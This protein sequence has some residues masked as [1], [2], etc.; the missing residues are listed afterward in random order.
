MG[1]RDIATNRYTE[2]CIERSSGS[3][4]CGNRSRGRH[5]HA[6]GVGIGNMASS[7][8]RTRAEV[9]A[10]LGARIITRGGCGDITHDELI[11]VV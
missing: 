4:P 3:K 1:L 7:C 2:R 11:R 6:K 5:E 8:G 9:I 10:E